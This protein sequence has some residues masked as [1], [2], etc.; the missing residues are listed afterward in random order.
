VLPFALAPFC[1]LGYARLS[2]QIIWHSCAYVKFSGFSY[3]A[4]QDRVLCFWPGWPRR[5]SSYD[6]LPHS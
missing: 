1:G 3:S 4:P 6:G 2:L 5:R